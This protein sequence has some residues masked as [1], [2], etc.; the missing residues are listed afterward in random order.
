MIFTETNSVVKLP[1][2]DTLAGY[3]KQI[4]GHGYLHAIFHASASLRF[5]FVL[6]LAYFVQTAT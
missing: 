4:T 2:D 1:R 3:Q 5:V 6:Y